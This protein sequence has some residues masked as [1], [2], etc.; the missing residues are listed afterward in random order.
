MITVIILT[1]NEEMHIKRC[2]DSIIGICNHIII[3]DSFS[4]DK[5]ITIAKQYGA[6]IY[7]NPFVNQA[8]QFQWALDHCDIKGDWI[9]RLD[10]DEYLTTDLIEEIINKV[11][12]IPKEIT[13]VYLKRQ[14]HFMGKWIRHGGYYPIKLLR[15]WR[16]NCAAI[17]QKWMDEH[18]VLLNG[19]HTEF[20]YDF[21]DDN[22]NNLQWWIQ[23]HNNYS[24]RETV[25]YFK[26][27]EASVQDQISKGHTQDAVKRKRKNRYYY[28]SPGFVRAFLYFLYR[29]VLKLGFLDGKQGLIW[30]FL[31]GFWYRFLVDAKIYQIEYLAKKQKQDV[32]TVIENEFGIKVK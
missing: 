3:I 5:T 8:I 32:W 21:V 30:H 25:E 4:Q 1:F 24:S 7:Q 12:K 22:L 16:K 6:E 31:Q 2:L 17:E 23:K 18:V 29:Y 19:K 10:A 9:L 28:K 13:G 15:L 20:T 26:L 27:K 14:V 11:N